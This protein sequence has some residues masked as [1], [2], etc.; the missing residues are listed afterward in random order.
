[1]K[2]TFHCL[3]YIFITYI[4]TATDACA[5]A[6]YAHLNLSMGKTGD[7]HNY[8]GGVHLG[9]RINPS[10]STPTY[11]SFELDIQY[12]DGNQSRSALEE[13]AIGDETLEVE[14]RLKV[15]IT[16]VPVLFNYKY[17]AL[18]ANSKLSWYAGAGLGMC[19]V[20]SK[21]IQS[22]SIP[23]IENL[24]ES[25]TN[26]HTTAF[27]MGQLFGGLSYALT[28]ALSIQAGAKI[29]NMKKMVFRLGN[30]SL[31]TKSF[32]TAVELGLTYSW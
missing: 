13:E 10:L 6:P 16:Q 17:N 20:K 18:I 21:V 25:D 3:I 5:S 19:L 14:N 27:L 26:S 32:Q 12:L 11:S 31:S 24:T 1:M 29:M 23:S 30:Q 7:F 9:Y 8:G 4:L 28:D 15:Y 22:T 2:T